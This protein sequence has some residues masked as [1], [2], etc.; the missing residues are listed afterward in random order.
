M[1]PAAD[2]VVGEAALANS[3]HPIHSQRKTPMASLQKVEWP[4]NGPSNGGPV[5]FGTIQGPQASTARPLTDDRMPAI[6][7]AAYFRAQRRGFQP[8]HELED[9]IAAEQDVIVWHSRVGD[10]APVLNH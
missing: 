6:T 1:E 10:A 2:Q 5:P 3:S 7:E 9:W 8:G 4:A